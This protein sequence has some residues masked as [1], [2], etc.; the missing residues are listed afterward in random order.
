MDPLYVRKA[1]L[2]A[3]TKRHLLVSATLTIVNYNDDGSKTIEEA[4]SIELG[5]PD[6]DKVKLPDKMIVTA[7]ASDQFKPR[8]KAGEKRP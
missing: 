6:E 1:F 4:V 2:K 7:D 5:E 3:T 8:Q